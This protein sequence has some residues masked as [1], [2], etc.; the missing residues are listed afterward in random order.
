MVIIKSTDDRVFGAYS[1][2]EGITANDGS[3]DSFT[4][5]Q[6]FLFSV[7]ADPLNIRKYNFDSRLLTQSIDNIAANGTTISHSIWDA[8]V[9]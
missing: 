5:A 1:S 7:Q 2:C 6:S 3:P 4:G 8:I 9:L